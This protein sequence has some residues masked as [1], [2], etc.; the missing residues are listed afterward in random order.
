MCAGLGA[1]AAEATEGEGGAREKAERQRRMRDRCGLLLI[2]ALVM[3][4]RSCGVYAQLL[5]GYRPSFLLLSC[6]SFAYSLVY[7]GHRHK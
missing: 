4:G 5:K 3:S 2:I 6:F 1:A 7:L